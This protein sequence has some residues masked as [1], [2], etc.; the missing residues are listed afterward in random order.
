MDVFSALDLPTIWFFLIGFLLI[1]Y[2]VLD[3]FDLG[4]GILHLFIA[5]DDRERRVLLNAIGPVWDGNEVWLVTAGG[6]LFG[7][8]P[9]AYATAFSGFYL[10]FK[11]LL[12]MLILRAISIEFRSKEPMRWWRAM[13]DRLFAIGSIGSTI[14]FGVTIGNVAQGLPI[15]EDYEFTHSSLIG[16]LTPYPLLVGLFTLSAFALHGAIYIYVKTDG[17]FQRRARRWAMWCLAIFCALY[18]STTAATLTLQPQMIINFDHL[19]PAWAVALLVVLALANV[20][21][22]MAMGYEWRALVTSACV[23]AGT[24]ALFGLGMYPIL[25]PSSLNDAWH[26]SIEKAASSEATLRTMLIMAILGV[27][28]VMAYTASIYW[29]FRGKVKIDRFSY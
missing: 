22:A 7:A 27:P 10:A 24:L 29:V 20:P 11:L 9:H 21:R 12:V 23:I 19:T 4:V 2:A 8:F 1:G 26:L 17:E 28:F 18:V 25:L 6:A 16:M 13:W 5:R 15:G 3:G 14:L